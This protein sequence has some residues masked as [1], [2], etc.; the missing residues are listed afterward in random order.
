[1][2]YLSA[3]G[4]LTRLAGILSARRG[5]AE[6]VLVGP[7]SRTGEAAPLRWVPP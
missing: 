4:R 3:V 6:L 1:M 5:R 7:M 2:V